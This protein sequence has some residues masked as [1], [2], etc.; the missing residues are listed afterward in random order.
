MITVQVKVWNVFHIFVKYKTILHLKSSLEMHD[1]KIW[2]VPHILVMVIPSHLEASLERY[3]CMVW[4]GHHHR[5]VYA[6]TYMVIY[7]IYTCQFQVR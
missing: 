2:N 6:A 4:N 7:K 3:D 1:N 5:N